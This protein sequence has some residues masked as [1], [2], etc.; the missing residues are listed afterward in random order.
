[1]RAVTNGQKLIEVKDGGSLKGDGNAD[2]MK[3]GSFSCAQIWLMG[4]VPKNS[5]NAPSLKIHSPSPQKGPVR[6]TN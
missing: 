1:M 6:C 3:K 4:N 2:G 5:F